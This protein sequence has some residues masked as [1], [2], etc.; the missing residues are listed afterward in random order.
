MNK[1][2]I[3]KKNQKRSI[4]KCKKVIIILSKIIS[5]KMINIFKFMKN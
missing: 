4:N 3:K 5:K 1:Q 2:F